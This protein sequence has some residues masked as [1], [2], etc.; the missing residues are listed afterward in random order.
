MA[1][2]ID[3]KIVALKLDHSDFQKKAAESVGMFGKLSDA[4]GKIRNVDLSKSVDALSSVDSAAKK[5]SLNPLSNALESVGGKFTAMSV[6]AITALSNITNKIVNV[7][8][9]MLK[10][11]T[12]DP[13]MDGFRE[14]ELKIGSVQ[15]I[16][17]NTD[18]KNTLEEVNDVLEVMNEYADQ[19]I[20]N[21]SEMTRNIGT[22]TAAGVD[23][24]TSAT[25]IKGIANLAAASG[26]NSQQASTAMYQLSQAISAGSVKLQDWNSVVNAGMGG[27]LFQNALIETADNMGI[28][29]TA[30]ENFRESLTDGWLTTEVLTETLKRFSEDQSMIDAATKVRTFS[31]LV[32]TAKEAVGSGWAQT[33][34]IVFGGFDDAT[35]L[36][37]S[38]SEA[39]GGF[40]DGLSDARNEMLKTWVDLGGRTKTIEALGNVM[41]ALGNIIKPVIQS[42]KNFFPDVT[43]EKLMN[44]TRGF[45]RLSLTFLEISTGVGKGLKRVFDVIFDVLGAGIGVLKSVGKWFKFLIP[46]DLLINAGKVIDFV[47]AF[48]GKVVQVAG[49]FTRA[50]FASKEF[51]EALGD[52]SGKFQNLTNDVR[53]FLQKGSAKFG[54]WMDEMNE[55]LPKMTPEI[56]G[57]FSDIYKSAI[58]LTTD[59]G[60]TIG[61]WVD[62]MRDGFADFKVSVVETL[63]SIKTY[64]KDTFNT[65]RDNARSFSEVMESI[66]GWIGE[67]ATKAWEI[68]KKIDLSQLFSV[69]GITGVFVIGKKLVDMF[70]TLKE[71]LEDLIPDKSSN[72]FSIIDDLKKSLGALTDSLKVDSLI[73]IAT[74][75]GILALS[76]TV[77]S[78]LNE[79]E[80]TRGLTAITGILV[81][82]LGSLHAISKSPV[83]VLKAMSASGLI[84]SLAGSIL[85]LSGALKV[86]STIDADDMSRSLL[87]LAGTMATVVAAIVIISNTG[88]GKIQTSALFMLGLA[89]S[90]KIMASAIE[91]LSEIDSDKIK[92]GVVGLGVI[93]LELAVF[94]RIADRTKIG[95]VSAAGLVVT[96]YAVKVMVTAIQDIAEI[97][98]DHLK[99]GLQTI[100]LIL[101]ELGLFAKFTGG[102]NL[103]LLGAGLTI[104]ANALLELIKPIW[105]LGKIPLKNL[106]TGIGA[107]AGAL[108]A[109]LLSLK[110][111]GNPLTLAITG[112]GLIIVAEALSMLVDPIT[113][114]GQLPLENL[115]LGIGAIA[116]ALL[117][118]GL[119]SNFTNLGGAAAIFVVAQGI[120]A[121]TTPLIRLSRLSLTQIATSLG[122]LAGTFTVIGV[123]AAVLSGASVSL[124]AFGA[125]LL[126][127]GGAVALIGG[128]LLALA[129]GLT[130]L[131]GVTVATIGGILLV[132]K[133]LVIGA[134]ELL[135]GVVTLVLNMLGGILQGIAENLGPILNAGLSIILTLLKGLRDNL[136]EFLDVGL[137][138]IMELVRGISDNWGPLLDTAA[139]TIIKLIDGMSNTLYE[140]GPRFV[141]SVINLVGSVLNIVWLTLLDIVDMFFG[142]IPGVTDALDAAGIAGTEALKDAFGIDVVVEDKTDSVIDYVNGRQGAGRESGKNLG[143]AL[144][145]G[146]AG[147]TGFGEQGA[148]KGQEFARGFS[149]QNERGKRSGRGMGLASRDGAAEV[150]FTGTGRGAGRQYVD[151][152]NT[153]KPQSRTSGV[154]LANATKEGVNSVSL[155]GAGANLGSGLGQGISSMT[156]DVRAKAA[157]LANEARQAVQSA[158]RIQSPSKDLMEDGMDFGRGLANGIASMGKV[159]AD[160]AAGIVVGARDAI[161]SF[162]TYVE[163]AV[164]SN[165]DI[166]PVITPVLDMSDIE[167][168]N[169]KIIKLNDLRIKQNLP[170]ETIH[171]IT[172]IN[173]PKTD[174]PNVKEIRQ[175]NKTIDK[176]SRKVDNISDRA[177]VVE[178]SVDGKVFS[179]AVAKPMRKAMDD[180]DLHRRIIRT[181]G[182]R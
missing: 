15:T 118:I 157:A 124:L 93:L 121:M 133:E 106:A 17:A 159:V 136:Y 36:F 144:K 28:A 96:A 100:G 139:N 27:K 116:A 70:D 23:L 105:S 10:S 92:Q 65:T 58:G 147:V 83:G 75:I 134:A 68:I 153:Q 87:A 41:K 160:K 142:W 107:I 85:V 48:V 155:H 158:V 115:A 4:F 174:D 37:T 111:A 9:Q 46:N 81:T 86:M 72:P 173:Q 54:K 43:G 135:P 175:L 146:V 140:E 69:A 26:S 181:G 171:T 62:S 53:V 178:N 165:I 42:F 25:S 1:R 76:M 30:S 123:A 104:V 97:K 114:L 176:L 21:F 149:N 77:L 45:E 71:K 177:I 169:T 148:L 32:D 84:A 172:A 99:K 117:S 6:V 7:G 129:T 24:E 162:S 66:F 95:P 52:V 8:T 61:D 91:D 35:E 128:G 39:F 11:F 108:V 49:N 51:Q 34:E 31:Q 57:F 127:V 13:I 120:D 88:G 16:M 126:M 122:M 12:V 50:Y 40:V 38:I 138:I 67:A 80:I 78:G 152:V 47:T 5:V 2:P 44:A 119:A 82:M 110:V 170:E 60:A 33:W 19:T 14:Y 89:G 164:Y 131:G 182:D 156:W 73:G 103:I 180:E 137:D 141:D 130:A 168:A 102:G 145:N 90:I 55:K 163:D 22:F 63:E 113:K 109:I 59:T 150:N 94:M 154:T 112:A 20:Y 18:G 29:H 101:L 151:G 125:G 64:F 166:S 98:T 167:K 79:D 143:N 179:K 3:E 161:K 132:F 74:A 56:V